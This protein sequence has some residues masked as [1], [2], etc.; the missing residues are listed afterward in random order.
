M[1]TISLSG[2]ITPVPVPALHV[3]RGVSLQIA[4]LHERLGGLGD[5]RYPFA[6]RYT[7]KGHDDRA[8]DVAG[9]CHVVISVPLHV[10]RTQPSLR[11]FIAL[12]HHFSV[13]TR[14]KQRGSI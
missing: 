11:G 9:A 6:I 12:V 2:P 13:W 4:R 8:Q 1:T 7:H 14:Q 5:S 10:N 3:A